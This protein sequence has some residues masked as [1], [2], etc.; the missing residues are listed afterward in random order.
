MRGR[1]SSDRR[2]VAS[3]LRDPK[4]RRGSGHDA[5]RRRLRPAPAPCS[6]ASMRDETPASATI[7]FRSS[8]SSGSPGLAAPTDA[9]QMITITRFC[10]MFFFI[11]LYMQNI[12]RLLPVQGKHDITPGRRSASRSAP[13]LAPQLLRP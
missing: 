3:R 5:H 4:S 7:C 1:A 12:L 11:T 2:H 6:S 13:E 10:S 9:T 8:R